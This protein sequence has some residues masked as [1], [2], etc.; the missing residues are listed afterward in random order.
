MLKDSSHFTI[1][2]W[3]KRTYRQDFSCV[4][5]EISCNRM[6]GYQFCFPVKEWHKLWSNLLFHLSWIPMLAS[7]VV[8]VCD[9]TMRWRRQR[10]LITWSVV[11]STTWS[12]LR[13]WHFG[14]CIVTSV[15]WFYVHLSGLMMNAILIF[16]VVIYFCCLC[17]FDSCF[18]NITFK[19][20]FIS[21]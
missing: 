20:K 6:A 19:Q 21:V 5:H 1:H 18:F 2:C 15:G 13:V 14:I 10:T 16:F 4:W 11:M 17:V 8:C 12:T 9:E 3:G 7:W